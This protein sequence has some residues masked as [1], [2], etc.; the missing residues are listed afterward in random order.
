MKD[1][2]VVLTMLSLVVTL[3]TTALGDYY[4][5]GGGQEN[6]TINSLK[7]AIKFDGSTSKA[8]LIASIG[9]IVEEVNEKYIPDDFAV[10][11]IYEA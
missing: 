5:S 7:V 9:R 2:V 3:C 6:L 8:N 1:R 11:S 10:C 4:Y